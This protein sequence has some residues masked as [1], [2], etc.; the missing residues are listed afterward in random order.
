TAAEAFKQSEAKSGVFEQRLAVDLHRR[1]D[2]DFQ[3][4]EFEGELMLLEYRFIAPAIRSIELGNQR[5]AIFNANL[6]YAVFIA[7]QGERAGVTDIAERFHR[8]ENGIRC[9]QGKR[10]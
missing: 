3:V 5:L 8:I 1:Y 6:E 4:G 9:E 7:V 2:G 10:V